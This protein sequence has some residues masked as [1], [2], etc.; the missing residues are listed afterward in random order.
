[1][2]PSAQT[3]VR[4]TF[5]HRDVNHGGVRKAASGTC[6]AWSNFR[7]SGFIAGN[8]NPDIGCNIDH[9]TA[10][11]IDEHV[12]GRNV[13]KIATDVGPARTETRCPP[14]FAASASEALDHGD[15]G[16]ACSVV[17]IHGD[18]VDGIAN[19]IDGASDIG[20]GGGSRA[21]SAGVVGYK[22]ATVKVSS[23]T[24]TGVDHFRP[25]RGF[26]PARGD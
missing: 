20:P 6:A 18:S 17:W 22:D 12:V 11:W 26:R 24:C 9:R 1:M 7:P 13:R 23:E 8:K 2:G 10:I 21:R 16:A 14:N 5:I 4:A 15:C 25:S 19:R 3:F